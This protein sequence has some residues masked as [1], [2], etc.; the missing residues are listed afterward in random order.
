MEV[1]GLLSSPPSV[2]A[3]S[4]PTIIQRPSRQHAQKWS[5]HQPMPKMEIDVFAHPKWRCGL[6]PAHQHLPVANIAGCVQLLYSSGRAHVWHCMGRAYQQAKP[7]SRS[8]LFPA[9]TESTTTKSNASSGENSKGTVG[10]IYFFS[11]RLD[12]PS[13][14][15]EFNGDVGDIK[16]GAMFR[17]RR[18]LSETGVHLPLVQGIHSVGDEVFS[19]VLCGGYEDDVDNGEEIGGKQRES[20]LQMCMFRLKT[21]STLQSTSSLF[22]G[23]Q[24]LS[25]PS[26]NV[27]QAS[28]R[29]RFLSGEP[30]RDELVQHMEQQQLPKDACNWYRNNL[31]QRDRRETQS[32][33]VCHRLRRD[34]AWSIPHNA[35]MAK[36]PY[37]D[38]ASNYSKR[39]ASYP[40]M[41]WTNVI[42]ANTAVLVSS[43]SR[44]LIAVN[45]AC[46]LRSA[47]STSQEALQ[48]DTY[49]VDVLE[50][51]HDLRCRPQASQIV[52]YKTAYYSF[53]L[54]VALA[55]R[56]TGILD[57]DPAPPYGLIRLP[58]DSH[59]AR[60]YFQVQDDWLDYAGTVEKLAKSAQTS[61][62][63][64]APGAS[65]RL[66]LW[67]T[68]ATCYPRCELRRETEGQEWR[69]KKVFEESALRRSMRSTRTMHS[70]ESL[71]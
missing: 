54:P 66:S 26:Q 33:D 36:Q 62:T 35:E 10:A 31:I 50:L 39:S 40:T 21:L 14:S 52:V 19:V 42:P 60:R 8:E 58:I 68:R 32:R 7:H 20:R 1:P 13:C 41:L 28:R 18:H 64:S 2:L 29:D 57:S 12:E 71:G 15:A 63:T 69:V 55:M 38:G 17:D 67:L 23:E 47:I 27:A 53:Y 59:S 16:P 65:T 11:M 46:M 45:D 43:T 4:T 5:L 34:P 9:F 30:I 70:A 25:T 24:R 3:D 37:L 56:L 61:S 22:H 44:T 51:F 49:Y 6:E 48:T